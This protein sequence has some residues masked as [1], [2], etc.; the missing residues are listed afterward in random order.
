MRGIFMGGA[1]ADVYIDNVIFDDVIYTFNSDGG[2]KDYGVYISNSY[3]YGWT[4]FSSVHK[5]VI[6]TKCTFGEG[7]GYAF[8]RPYNAASFVDCDFEAGYQLDARGAV[9]FENCTIGGVALTAENL[10]TLVTS[11]IENATV[12]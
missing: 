10:A 2:N 6:F 4:S 3:L 8:C 11:N 12:K 7:N 1:T 5:E 9:T